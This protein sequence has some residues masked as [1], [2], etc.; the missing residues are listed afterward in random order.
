MGEQAASQPL[1]SSI[2]SR[3]REV[4]RLIAQGYTSQQIADML[5]ISRR[6]VLTHRH[7]L[8][9]KTRANNTA[10]LILYAVSHQLLGQLVPFYLMV[11]RLSAR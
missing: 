1:A 4:L 2:S 5:F 9:N 11:P 7:N 3:E 6:T 8:L 10:R